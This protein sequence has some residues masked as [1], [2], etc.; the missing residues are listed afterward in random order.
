MLLD[1]KLGDV[2]AIFVP[3]GGGYRRCIGFAPATRLGAD[4]RCDDR[5]EALMGRPGALARDVRAQAESRS[6]RER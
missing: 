2:D 3:F 5:A 6:R 4:P 1:L